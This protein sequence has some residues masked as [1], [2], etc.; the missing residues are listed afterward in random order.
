MNIHSGISLHEIELNV[1]LGWPQQERAQSQ[2]VLVD[3]HIHFKTPPQGCITDNLD[4]TY[5][6]DKL[7][8]TLKEK[9]A[10]REF[11][12]IEHLGHEIYQIIKSYITAE[13]CIT[14]RVTKH[15]KIENLKGGVSFF[16]GDDLVKW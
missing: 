8:T 6:Y 13:T 12:L 3:I 16:Y 7:I 10:K 1:L 2:N 4:E 9:L 14:T 15:P 11:H 5:C